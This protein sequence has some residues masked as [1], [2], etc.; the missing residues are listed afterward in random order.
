M[1][2]RMAGVPHA[3][4]AALVPACATRL[5]VALGTAG[6]GPFSHVLELEPAG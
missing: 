1:I 4:S 3:V 2:V 5:T 6:A